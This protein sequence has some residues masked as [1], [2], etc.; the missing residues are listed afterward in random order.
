[1]D[2]NPLLADEHG[3]IALDARVVLERSPAGAPR[4]AHVAIHPYPA[5]L[6]TRWR[7]GDGREVQVRPIRAEDA[8]LEQEFVRG[9]SA[10]ARQFRFLA[11]LPAL[12]PQMLTRFTQI[13]YVR[14][15]ALIAVVTEGGR[16]AQ[17]GV[18]RFVSNPD[19]ETAEF[20]IVI[21]DAWRRRGLGRHLLERLAAIARERG[22]RAL[23]G[24]VH[25]ANG[26]MLGLA[27]RLGFEIERR[28]LDAGLERVTL[29][30]A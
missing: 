25:P 21:A 8:A 7:S 20:A 15:L 28:G 27:R 26:A 13:D 24:D 14:E 3:A 6:A 23:V 22:L 16:E 4:Y 17:V 18:A 19:G 9:L 30:L 29:R 11:A 5:E 2:I 12:S 10:E 1:M